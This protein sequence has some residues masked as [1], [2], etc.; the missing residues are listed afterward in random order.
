LIRLQKYLAECGIASRREA[1]KLIAGGRV[2]IDGRTATLGE[3]V[4]PAKNTITFDGTPV[5]HEARTYVVL[6]KPKG[7][8]TT[9][10]DTHRRKTVMDFLAGVRARVFPVGRLDMDV[11]GAVILTNNGDLAYRLLHPKFEIDKV[12]VARVQGRMT[13]EE[14]ARLAQGVELDD[15]TTAP[16]IVRILG[17]HSGQSRIELTLH[18][19][20]KHEVK[21]MCAAVGHPV[22]H[23]RRES[24]GGIHVHDLRPGEWRYLERREI[25]ALHK[26]AGL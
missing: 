3:T 5:V 24:T 10:K 23:L 14:A 21:R 13:P 6:N 11:E 20:R 7:V 25:A 2:Q 16:A 15:G 1:E 22:V 26:L 9:V 12:Y 8:V 19:G 18:E 4:D 17:S